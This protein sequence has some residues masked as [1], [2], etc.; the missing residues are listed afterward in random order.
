MY[1]GGRKTSPW[2]PVPFSKTLSPCSSVRLGNPERG[3]ACSAQFLTGAT[4][5]I[6]I[7]EPC[8]HRDESSS[9]FA[10]RGVW[11]SAHFATSSTR[12]RPRL[13]SAESDSAAFCAC[14]LATPKLSSKRAA[15]QATPRVNFPFVMRYLAFRSMF[16]QRDAGTRME[17]AAAFAPLQQFSDA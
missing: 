4:G 3:G 17:N 8:I 15:A 11:H 16:G 5:R 7:V 12:Y 1:I 9:P 10:S 14:D 6:Q 2:G 13:I